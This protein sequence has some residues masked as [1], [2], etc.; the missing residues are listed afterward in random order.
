MADPNIAV[1]AGP[2]GVRN[3]K[4]VQ[5]LLNQ[6]IHKV[7]QTTNDLSAHTPRKLKAQAEIRMLKKEN[8]IITKEN[9]ALHKIIKKMAHVTKDQFLEDCEKF[10]PPQIAMFVREQVLSD[11]KQARG[12]RYS[13]QFKRL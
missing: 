1:T 5:P 9:A 12:R 2:S 8:R 10:L 6:S 4:G 13:L 7:T 11:K 3:H